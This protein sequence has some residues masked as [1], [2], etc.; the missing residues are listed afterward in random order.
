M[1]YIIS[2]KKLAFGINLPVSNII[3]MDDIGTELTFSTVYQLMGRAGRFGFSAYAKIYL[4][5]MT[6]EKFFNHIRKEEEFS[7][8]A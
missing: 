4:D 7:I 5:T 8:E 1:A 6:R 2:D 3:I